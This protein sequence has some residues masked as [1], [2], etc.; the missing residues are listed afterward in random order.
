MSRRHHRSHK[1]GQ[2]PGS[3]IY[4]GRDDARPPEVT[5]TDYHEEAFAVHRL[6]KAG[7]LFA[8]AETPGIRWI[9]IEGIG[10]A[11]FLE[12]LGQRYAIH[13]LVLEDIL[14]TEQRPKIDDLEKYLYVV[15][16]MVRPDKGGGRPLSEQLSLILGEQQVISIQEGVAGDPFGAVRK[17]IEGGR[18]RIRQMGS[19]YLLYALLDSIVD[20][21]F[22]VLEGLG[23]EI[24]A[25][26]DEIVAGPGPEAVQRIHRLKRDL[27]HLRR[28]VWPLREVLSR[29]ERRESLLISSETQI[30]FRDVY[31]HVIQIM[32]GIESGREMLS[33]LLDIYLS[34]ISNRMNQVMKVLTVISTIFIPLT[35]LAGIYGMNF[36]F[37]PEL[38]WRW[39]YPALWGVMAVLAGGMLFLFRR[40]K[41]F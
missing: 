34:S 6:A 1:R 38:H 15:V 39:G 40:K 3:L 29:L 16:K 41:W 14:T 37:F 8:L 35:F 12:K 22:E 5:V 11:K 19:D 26:E 25:L 13:P 24:E 2:S 7:A 23:E 32:D 30:F 28:V 33:S 4:V 31:D 10:D 20:D 17:R 36:D 9:D 18:G 21:Y 27:I